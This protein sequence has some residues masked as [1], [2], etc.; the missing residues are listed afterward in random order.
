MVKINKT[1]KKELYSTIRINIKRFLSLVII[2]FLGVGFYVGMKSNAPVLQNTMVKMFEEKEL[3]DLQVM[4]LIGLSQNELDQIKDNIAG[5]EKIEGAYEQDVTISV[6]KKF[7]TEERNVNVAVHSYK[8]GNTLNKLEL[9]GDLGNREIQ[10]VDECIV[11]GSMGN[12]GFKLGDKIYLGDNF[13]YPEVTIVGFSRSPLYISSIDKGTTSLSSGKITYYMYVHEDNFKYD[14]IYTIGYIKLD[15]DLVAFTDEYN[16][17]VSNI[18]TKIKKLS[19]KI[20]Q[21]RYKSIIEDGN[22]ELDKGFEEYYKNE[23]LVKEEIEKAEKQIS[24]GEKQIANAEKQLMSD[25]EIDIYLA[26]IEAQLQSA[27]AQL[28]SSKT[29]IQFI[30][31]AM[32]DL[33]ST[34]IQG[35]GVKFT[36]TKEKLD[37]AGRTLTVLLQNYEQLQ[38]ELKNA[39]DSCSNVKDSTLKSI[40]DRTISSIQI[41]IDN[42]SAQIENTRGEI[43]QLNRLLEY[44]ESFDGMGFPDYSSYVV[45]ME[46]EYKESYNKYLSSLNEFNKAKSSLKPQIQ[47]ARKEIE[48]KKIELENG[49]IELEQKKKD[50]ENKLK[51]GYSELEKAQ[52][53]LKTL[54]NSDWYVFTRNDNASYS[55]Y[56]DDIQRIDSI[57]KII[58]VVFFLVAALVTASSIT[59]MVKEE[60]TKI[61]LLKSLGYT[62]KQVLYKY[63][64]YTGIATLIGSVFGILVGILLFPNVFEN[65][66]SLMYFIPDLKYLINPWSIILALFFAFVSS[67]V[68]AYFTVRSSTKEKPYYLM[69]PKVEKV[70]GKTFIEKNKKMWKKLSF[71][72]KIS[73][74]NI[75]RSKGK[76]LMTILGVMGCTSLII[77]GFEVRS[78]IGGLIY[79]QYGELWDVNSEFYYKDN[80]TTQEMFDEKQRIEAS[81]EVEKTAISRIESIEMKNGNKTMSVYNLAVEDKNALYKLANL[82]NRKTKEKLEIPDDGV[83]ITEKIAKIMDVKVGGN[84]TYIDSNGNERTVK[85][86]GIAENYLFHYIFMSKDYYE[87]LYG[88]E[89]KNNFLLVKYNDSSDLKEM[90]EFVNKENKFAGFLD[91]SD[92]EYSYNQVMEKF[93]IIIII[94][95]ISAGL[96]AFVVLYN[97]SKINISERI[98]E[99]ATLKVLG[100][101]AKEVNSYINNEMFTLIAIG[102]FI[103]LFSGYVLA[104]LVIN[105]CEVDTVMFKRGMDITSYIYAVIL[106]VIFAL[107]IDLIVKKDLKEVNMVEAL[108]SIE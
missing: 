92:A 78:S 85:V 74:R 51:E 33:S 31:Q 13:K 102:I 66:Y 61:G 32:Y 101:R 81:K 104:Q 19:K 37:K 87:K 28:D 65:I 86:V 29:T 80:L 77:V 6:Q 44:I 71:M 18:K 58:P 76:S 57:A 34:N 99:I 2:M 53:Q 64:F 55:Q 79:L 93:D 25:S 47:A 26:S 100:F 89:Y 20:S 62:D 106:T 59:R 60:R 11:D 91:M 52:I 90:N 69:R 23:K 46:K 17:Y 4:S 82:R 68:V 12:A 83:I 35:P 42:V 27:K 16:S 3:M 88:E 14:D 38:E 43:I 95:I 45:Q 103:G 67:V 73:L 30:K 39:K 72:K 96:L 36:D 84:A 54:S 97:L 75:A 24:D 5:I 40:C 1:L 7:N 8:P 41:K 94:I 56:Y 22:K 70:K 108:K 9:F 63:L 98:R 48:S 21:E 50:A 10:N 107:V 15:T 105:T 49:K